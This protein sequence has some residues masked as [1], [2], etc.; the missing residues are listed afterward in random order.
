MTISRK[1]LVSVTAAALA[2]SGTAVAHAQSSLSSLSSSSAVAPTPT[3]KVEDLSGVWVQKGTSGEDN[4]MEAVID[5]DTISIDWVS[6]GGDTHAIYW[7]G[8]FDS[9][10]GGNGASFLSERDIEATAGAWLASMDT[11]KEFSF[12]NGE[13]SFSR[14]VMGITTTIRM[15][16]LES[17]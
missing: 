17:S 4:W 9:E 7:I 6:G 2:I 16:K 10:L 15:E 12:E 5:Q 1:I 8:T 3:P 13:L 14:S 11:S